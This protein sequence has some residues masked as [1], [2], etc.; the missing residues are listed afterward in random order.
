MGA[1]HLQWWLHKHLERARLEQGAD[2]ARAAAAVVG[3]HGRKGSARL[4]ELHHGVLNG[5]SA[6]A[7]AAVL[8]GR[9]EGEGKGTASEEE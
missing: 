4:A 8:H 6:L 2:T 1:T 7:A 5:L 3:A 9:E